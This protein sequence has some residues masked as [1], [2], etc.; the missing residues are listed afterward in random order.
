LISL[1]AGVI[2]A[3]G[4][5]PKDEARKNLLAYLEK[6]GVLLED[7]KFVSSYAKDG[8]Y[9]VNL[10]A[11]QA[12]CEMPML[13]VDGKWIAKGMSCNGGYFTPEQAKERR[14]M[15]LIKSYKDAAAKANAKLPA[16]DQGGVRTD[17]IT[18]D[19]NQYIVHVTSANKSGDYTEADKKERLSQYQTKLCSDRDV[20]QALDA[21]IVF[22][23][24]ATG[25]DGKPAMSVRVTAEDCKKL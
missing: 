21:G 18:F 13:K 12:T 3:C 1:V 19:N 16:T 25:T 11:G 5:P 22:G 9:T 4:G 10:M 2:T 7:I 8:G 15:A 24:D 17:K 23:I 14:K 6:D 20:F